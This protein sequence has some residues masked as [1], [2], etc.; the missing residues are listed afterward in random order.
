MGEAELIPHK[1]QLVIRSVFFFYGNAASDELSKKIARDI[2]QHWNEA[3]VIH[4][5]HDTYKVLFNIEG[6]Y[7]KY[8]KPQEVFENTDP[9]FNYF[10]IEKTS[11]MEVS[12]VDGIGSNTGYFLLSNL[13]QDST[14]AAHEYGHTLGLIH[15]NQLDIRGRGVPGIMYPRGTIVD[16]R[17]QYNPNA[18]A[19]DNTNGGTMNP[20][21][22]K[23]LQEDIDNLQLHKLPFDKNGFAVVGDFSSIWHEQYGEI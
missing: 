16:Y 7:A 23:V 12:F 21:S 20:F 17:H 14:T 6:V 22:R 4:L 11:P 2:E 19:G 10:R 8:L 1:K 9:K 13:L 18:I 5:R 3:A 15:P